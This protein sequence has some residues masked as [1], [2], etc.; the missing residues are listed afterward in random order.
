LSAVDVKRFH[1]KCLIS[2]SV[3]LKPLKGYEQHFLVKSFPLGFVFASKIPTEQELIDHYKK[4]P[5]TTEISPITIRRYNELLDDFEKYRKTGRILDIGC[6]VGHF[7]KEAQKRGWGV[8]GT[9]F[10]DLP[11]EK[12]RASGIHMNKGKLD[13]AWYNKGMFDIVTSFEVIEH[14]NNPVE[15]VRNINLVLREGGLLYVTT[16]NFNSVER[17]FLKS[18]HTAICYPDHLCYYTPHTL[19]H[20]LKGNGFKK[21]KIIATGFSLNRLKAGLNK[22]NNVVGTSSDEKI[23]KIL[24]ANVFMVLIKQGINRLLSLLGIGNAIKGWFIKTKS[25]IN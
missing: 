15:E 18:K 10:T 12:C 16:P 14:I 21:H 5:R 24:D 11:I 25:I 23:R 19:N 6:D 1:D 4:Y 8:N 3:I 22:T 17:Y 7:L 9:E 20:L 2:G 13:P